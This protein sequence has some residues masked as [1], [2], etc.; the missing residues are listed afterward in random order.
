MP[1]D[2]TGEIPA[3]YAR[4]PIWY[5]MRPTIEPDFHIDPPCFPGSP[6][7]DRRGI[8]TIIIRTRNRTPE[9]AINVN[10]DI[11][12]LATRAAGVLSSPILFPSRNK[13]TWGP[14]SLGVRRPN[15]QIDLRSHGSPLD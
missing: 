8:S 9:A 13:A 11:H 3:D 2:D 4:P 15:H 1:L 7:T 12:P 14:H 5:W 10:E 6:V